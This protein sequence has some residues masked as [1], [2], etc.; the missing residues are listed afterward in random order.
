[1]I[2]VHILLLLSAGMST[3][4]DLRGTWRGR[5]YQG[6]EGEFL[7]EL[8]ITDQIE[9]DFVGTAYCKSVKG[10]YPGRV[11]YS[12]FL[13]RYGKGY[14][15]KDL[16]VIQE[17]KAGSFFW[18]MK[19]GYL[20]LNVDSAT[21]TMTLSGKWEASGCESGTLSVSKSLEVP[22]DPPETPPLFVGNRLVETRHEF[23]VQTDTIR[24]E[25][26][27]NNEE[28]GDIISLNVDGKWL[29]RDHLL[30]REKVDFLIPLRGD[31]VLLVLH[32]ENLGSIPPNTAAISIYDG[33]SFR[34]VTLQSNQTKSEGIW[35]G[36]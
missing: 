23:E 25:C 16:E 34:T 14:D 8:K 18:C 10:P 7:C 13:K 36:R 6:E 27:D 22:P 1:M 5:V 28:D 3:A 12:T 29:L 24:I 11:K 32:A 4:Q 15:Y 9:S 26:W 19:S 21:Q 31:G 35:I 20:E 33:Q 30:T 2:L 17:E